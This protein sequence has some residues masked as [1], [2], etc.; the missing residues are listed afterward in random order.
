MEM[1][2]ALAASA[3]KTGRY[4]EKENGEERVCFARWAAMPGSRR[5]A[6]TPEEWELLSETLYY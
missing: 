5:R 4:M 1:D 3:E 6:A 2:E